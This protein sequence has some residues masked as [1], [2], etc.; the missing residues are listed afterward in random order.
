MK[1]MGEVVFTRT[2]HLSNKPYKRYF[3]NMKPESSHVRNP[4][5]PE[6]ILKVDIVGDLVLG[7]QV[8]Q[9]PSLHSI[10]LPRYVT[11]SRD[12]QRADL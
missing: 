5:R 7:P 6:R 1:N 10:V 12:F 4:M 9:P 11:R 3:S 2:L 8:V